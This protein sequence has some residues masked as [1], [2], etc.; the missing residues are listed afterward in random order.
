MVASTRILLF[1]SNI[2][3]QLPKES[4]PL[5]KNPWCQVQEALLSLESTD[6][7]RLSSF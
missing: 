6:K 5:A 3:Q 1:H 2:D 4:L 7:P